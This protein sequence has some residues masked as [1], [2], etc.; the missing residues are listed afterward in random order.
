MANVLITS[1]VASMNVDA[2][3]LAGVPSAD[4]DNGKLVTLGAMRD[5][6]AYAITPATAT[7]TSCWIV[8]GK[9]PSS[10]INGQILN[11]PRYFTN[12]ANIPTSIRYLVPHVDHIKV[13]IPATSSPAVGKYVD[14]TG[15]VAASAPTNGT[16]FAIV[17]KDKIVIG[18]EVVDAYILRCERN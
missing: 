1:K 16:Y 18:Q 5:D 11:D 9:L 6:Y 10:D 15:A 7:S 2:M 4:I 12:K 14:A 8:D 3:V 17:K 13:I